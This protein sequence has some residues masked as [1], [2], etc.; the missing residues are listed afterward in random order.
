MNQE[1]VM[2]DTMAAKEAVKRLKEVRKALE[3]ERAGGELTKDNLQMAVT[4]AQREV[5]TNGAAADRAKRKATQL[6]REIDEWKSWFANL[7]ADEQETGL[8]T[9]QSEI[10]WRAAELDKLTPQI[11]DLL[12]VAAHAVSQLELANQQRVAFEAGVFDRPL[13]EDPRLISLKKQLK[14]LA[15]SQEV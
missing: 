4:A 13:D 3:R 12:A 9:L 14:A 7:P 11:A 8:V 15:H 2:D 5:E 6:K 1:M 10:K